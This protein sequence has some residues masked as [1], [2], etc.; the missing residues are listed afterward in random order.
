MTL[1][2]LIQVEIEKIEEENLKELYNLIISFIQKKRQ[3]K[4]KSLLSNLKNIKIKG[5]EDFSINHE[6]YASG[7]KHAEAD[8]H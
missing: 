1:K 2:E 7:K 6:L 4:K 8:F 5:P 3:E